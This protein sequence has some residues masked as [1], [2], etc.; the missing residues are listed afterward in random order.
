MTCTQINNF[1]RDLETEFDALNIDK[2][3]CIT[4]KDVLFGRFK[5]PKYDL[6]NHALL[7]AKY[8]LHKHFVMRTTP[9]VH[10]FIKYYTTIL[11]TEKQSCVSKNKLI[12]FNFRFGK[13][14]LTQKLVIWFTISPTQHCQHIAFLI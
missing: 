9:S 6:L 4:P 1:W 13:C 5:Q 10:G 3:C 11:L 2:S 14:L 7:H 8:F 12:E